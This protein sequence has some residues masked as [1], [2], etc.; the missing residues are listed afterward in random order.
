[1]RL[2]TSIALLAIGSA[3]CGPTTPDPGPAA[4]CRAAIREV[5]SEG[6]DH[7]VEGTP[8]PYESNPPASGPHYPQWARYQRHEEAVPRGYWVHNV[9]HGAIVLLHRP[10]VSAAT[11][12]ELVSFY[13][14]IAA[15]SACGHPRALLTPDPQLPRAVA[16]VAADFVLEA[17]C[18]PVQALTDFV[19]ARR[20]RGP[21]NVCSD[22]TY[23]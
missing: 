18:V 3:A 22:G 11:L 15:D 7:Y 21:E 19:A 4:E 14:G 9:E 13:E 17:D 5:P 1:M 8:L 20:G 6:W 16:A 10:D 12:A 2:K 23:P